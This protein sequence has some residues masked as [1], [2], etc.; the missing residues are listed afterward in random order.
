MLGVSMADRISSLDPGYVTGDLSLYPAV[1]DDPDILYTAA[2]NATTTLKQTLTYNG[3]IVIVQD[4]TGFAP[5]GQIRVG[6]EGGDSYELIAYQQI[7]A[8][9]F[10]TLQRGFA[11]SEQNVWALGAVV[12]NSVMADHHNAVK[13]AL[14]NTE[15]NLGTVALPDAASLNGILTAQEVRFLSPK[16]LFRAFPISG[17]PPLSVRF[18]NFTTGYII[19]YLW[20]F[21]D[22]ST[23]L[24]KSPNYTYT[25]EGSYTVQLNVITY[26]GGQ[27]VQIK[28][29]YITVSTDDSLPFFYVDN[30]ISPYSIT[31]AADII[32]ANPQ[33][34]VVPK[35]FLFIDQSDGDIVQRN[36]VFGDGNQ[37][38]VDDPDAHTVNH[39]YSDPGD[40]VVTQLIIFSNGKL[41]RA[42][43]PTTLTVL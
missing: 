28:T 1:L 24:D 23:S 31:T 29:D 11:G 2:N 13:D 5:T 14:I 22:G 38:V 41:K 7:I 32:A 43:L 42:E 12:T 39:V 10:Q 21:G 19:R 33:S 9:T 15:V 8:N 18:Q 35:N 40:Y 4:A 17:A 30:T 25:Q 34:T 6:V 36:W 27:G 26:N 16:P 20:D 3:K 37:S